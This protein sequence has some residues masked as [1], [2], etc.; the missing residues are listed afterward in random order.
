MSVDMK[1]KDIHKWCTK[2]KNIVVTFTKMHIG[3]V[4]KLNMAAVPNLHIGGIILVQLSVYAMKSFCL[5]P[6]NKLNSQIKYW[7]EMAVTRKGG[8]YKYWNSSSLL[9]IN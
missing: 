1:K 5:K 9:E 4:G 6:M 7:W 8:E 2:F 3:M